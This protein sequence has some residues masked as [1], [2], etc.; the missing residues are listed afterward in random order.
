[1]VVLGLELSWECNFWNEFFFE[2]ILFCIKSFLKGQWAKGEK[3]GELA[4]VHSVKESYLMNLAYSHDI[5][6]QTFLNSGFMKENVHHL[7]INS[8]ILFNYVIFR[9]IIMYYVLLW[10]FSIY[11][12]GGKYNSS[13]YLRFPYP[14]QLDFISRGVYSTQHSYDTSV[15]IARSVLL[16]NVFYKVVIIVKCMISCKLAW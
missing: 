3:F 10:A 12:R 1:M 6:L 5:N 13:L 4:P 15:P 2:R 9:T 16:V 8:S 14:S 11:G 7:T